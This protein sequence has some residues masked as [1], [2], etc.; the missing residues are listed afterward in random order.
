MHFMLKSISKIPFSASVISFGFNDKKI[1]GNNA[2]RENVDSNS[3][4]NI[5]T[6]DDKER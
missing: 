5:M 3:V 6:Y 2:T 4:L 1:E